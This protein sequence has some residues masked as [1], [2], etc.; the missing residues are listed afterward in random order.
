[1]YENTKNNLFQRYRNKQLMDEY[2]RRKQYEAERQNRLS[3]GVGNAFKVLN[4]INKAKQLFDKP[5][6][7]SAVGNAINFG[8]NADLSPVGNAINSNVIG[9]AGNI[10]SEVGNASSAAQGASTAGGASQALG[11]A[12][13]ALAV[14][15]DAKNM[16]DNGINFNNGTDMAADA[17]S[18]GLMATGVGAPAA[19]AVQ[20][21]KFIKNMVTGAIEK[22]KQKAM[23]ASMKGAAEEQEKSMNNLAEQQQGFEEQRQNNMANLQN[24]MQTM[25]Q[26]QD[27]NALVQDILGQVTGGASAQPQGQV[28]DSDTPEMLTGHVEQLQPQ[29]YLGNLPD[30][31]QNQRDYS[32]PEEIQTPEV[33]SPEANKQSLLSMLG[34]KVGDFAN[35]FSEGYD[36]NLTNGFKQGDLYNNTIGQ[37]QGIDT[38]GVVGGAAP[39]NKK[40]I[41]QRLG[42]VAGTGTRIMSN[43]W[44][45]AAIAGLVSKAAG[46][47]IDDMAKAAFDYGTKKAQSNYYQN[48]I[49]PGSKPTALSKYTVDDY[50]AKT[51]NDYR[52]TLN[53]I[54]K[55]KI[56]AQL[57]QSFPLASDYYASQLASGQMSIDDYNNIISDP[58]YNPNQRISLNTIKTTSNANYQKGNLEAKNR[59]ID[60]QYNLGKERNAIGW[61]NANN[62]TARVGETK[63]HN[64]VIEK[65]GQDK[66]DAK[67]KEA[68]AKEAARMAK[69]QDEKISSGKYVLGSTPDGRKVLV[70]REQ[71]KEFRRNG[72]KI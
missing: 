42:E 2:E 16:A 24:Q 11:T 30:L 64:E 17:A 37:N 72:G 18:L 26:P 62:G 41:G 43:P 59:Q 31:G 38:S 70:P 44:T 46:G 12:G 32:F 6:Q 25:Q 65:Q 34:Q 69:E 40:T 50:K 61:T 71:V 47:D 54:N 35:N 28:I 48:I 67:A 20:A 55:A 8:N 22:K 7:P 23:Q 53:N 66:I 63:R 19:A 56:Q 15:L 39:T 29:G 3:N 58:N 51:M 57:D 1:M 5:Y 36:D 68:Q 10:G 52:D 60:N 13:S 21:A 9:N 4:G 45:H 27:N 14:G 33:G 49:D